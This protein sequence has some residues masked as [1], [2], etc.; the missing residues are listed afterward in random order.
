MKEG[1]CRI[2]KIG[3]I[4]TND[5]EGDAMTV[6]HLKTLNLGGN[7]NPKLSLVKL[8]ENLSS[9]NFGK[10]MIKIQKLIFNNININN[11]RRNF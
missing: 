3:D 10:E 6:R 4:C 9:D 11:G 1:K 8:V 5:E 2:T 7:Q